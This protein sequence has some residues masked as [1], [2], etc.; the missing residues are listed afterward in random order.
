MPDWAKSGNIISFS[1]GS[2]RVLHTKQTQNINAPEVAVI[3]NIFPI[4][5]ASFSPDSYWMAFEGQVDNVRDLY[6]VAINGSGLTNLTN[7]DALDFHPD[8]QP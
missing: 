8:W 5:D 7:D 6:I 2:T 4:R 3:Q 1:G